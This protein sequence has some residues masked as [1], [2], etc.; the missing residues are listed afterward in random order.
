MEENCTHGVRYGTLCAWCGADLG[1][2]NHAMT[3]TNSKSVTFNEIE[4]SQ[5]IHD[6]FTKIKEK[7]KLC[8]LIHMD[9]VII[10]SK[11]CL[12]K[13][14]IAPSGLES[15]YFVTNT[16]PPYLVRTRP[17][18]IECL[19]RLSQKYELRIFSVESEKFI[20]EVLLHIDPDND[21]FGDRI[22]SRTVL[23]NDYTVIVDVSSENWRDSSNLPVCGFVQ[24]TPFVGLGSSPRGKVFP[25]LPTY[26]QKYFQKKEDTAMIGLTNFLINI[27]S[28]FF[29]DENCKINEAIH[30]AYSQVFQNCIIC[31]SDLVDSSSTQEDFMKFVVKYG[32][33]YSPQFTP[34]CTHIIADSPESESVKQAQEYQGVYIITFEWLIESCTNF[35][36][37]DENNFKLVGVES[38]TKGTKQLE[39]MGPDRDLSS[40]EFDNMMNETTTDSMSEEESSYISE[41]EINSSFSIP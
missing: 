7:G 37:S 17:Y 38:P 12:D 3:M 33:R 32:G 5:I 41:A 25:L 23:A 40:S 24:V 39:V 35:V 36:K 15:Q 34:F 6:H 13:K 1:I 16:E 9:Q 30:A 4:A 19:K 26:S 18:L 22:N 2:Q 28:L 8:L 27:H 31:S 14:Y 10:D 29:S 20:S 11:V 21:Y